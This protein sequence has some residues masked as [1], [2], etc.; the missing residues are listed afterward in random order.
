MAEIIR[1]D[2]FEEKVLEADKPVLVDFYAD[3]CGPCKMM[4]PVLDELSAEKAGELTIYK[5]NVDENPDIARRYQVMSIPTMILFKDGQSVKT[6]MGAMTK[7]DLW[8]QLEGEL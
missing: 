3:W 1:Q 5:I 2:V 4:I 7:K 6:V 8:K